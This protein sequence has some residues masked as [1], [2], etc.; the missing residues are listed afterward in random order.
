MKNLLL[1]LLFTASLQA[2]SI[3]NVRLDISQISGQGDFELYFQFV[4]QNGLNAVTV[5]SISVAP[6]QT[7]TFPNPAGAFFSDAIIPFTPATNW[8]D[9]QLLLDTTSADPLF[10][11]FF[12]FGLNDSTGAPLPT[13]DPLGTDFLLIV[14]FTDSGPVIE[15][16]SG[17]GQ[18]TAQPE[19]TQV[20]EPSTWLL[21][22]TAPLLLLLKRK[23]A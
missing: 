9:F 2:A 4:N 20:P 16:Y 13:L 6:G 10:P 8:L 1:L 7:L 15:T 22:A 18:L 21:A 5:Q 19:V 14:D 11:D 12:G 3:F 17:T 23:S